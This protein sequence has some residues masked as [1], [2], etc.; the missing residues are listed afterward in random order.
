MIPRN[1]ILSILTTLVFLLSQKLNAFQEKSDKA[2]TQWFLEARPCWADGRQVEPNVTVHL[3]AAPVL[4]RGAVVRLR[5]T[6]ASSYRFFLNGNF[7]GH[8]PSIAAHDYFRVDEYDL[9]SKIR[10]GENHLAIEVAGYNID[11]YF[12]PNQPSFVQAELVA[13]GMVVAATLPNVNPASFRMYLSTQRIREVPKLSFQR[14]HLEA[15]RLTTGYSDWRSNAS[16]PGTQVSIEETD[17][18]NLLPRRVRYPD[19]SIRS[20]KERQED[21]TFTFPVNTTGFLQST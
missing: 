5:I 16:K 10:D 3:K 4:R 12:I 21:G 14:P 8:G 1:T 11:N 2:E 6:A 20:F 9:S 7:I 15:Y 18:K 17:R 13:D 19:Y